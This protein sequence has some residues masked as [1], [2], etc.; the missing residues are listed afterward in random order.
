MPFQR[1]ESLEFVVCKVTT[2]IHTSTT[3]SILI[4]MRII[5]SGF[6]IDSMYYRNSNT[7]VSI[8]IN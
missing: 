8:L 2:D 7:H 6:Y 1:L 5:R 3:S 4:V